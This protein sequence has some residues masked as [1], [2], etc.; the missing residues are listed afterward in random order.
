MPLSLTLAC[1]W[2]LAAAGAGAAPRRYHWTAAWVLIGIGIP[3]L[4]F[5]TFQAGPFWG[6]ACLAA[7]ASVLRWP[8]IRLS[9]WVW[10][11][12]LG[13]SSD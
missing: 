12:T 1:L 7:G 8:L 4:G 11:Q 6:L 5:V 3:L 13:P 9:Q 2:V 10:R